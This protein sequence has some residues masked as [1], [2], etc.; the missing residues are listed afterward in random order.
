[1]SVYNIHNFYLSILL[2]KGLVQSELLNYHKTLTAFLKCP[3]APH[4]VEKKGRYSAGQV[5]L[6]LEQVEFV[7][8]RWSV[9]GPPLNLEVISESPRVSLG[10]GSRDLLAGMTQEM[11]LTVHSGSSNITKVL[12]A[13]H[14]FV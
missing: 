10:R 4:Q 7:C 14:L 5:V 1:M 8:G 11:V 9:G 6:A 13:L 3:L 2:T 12:T